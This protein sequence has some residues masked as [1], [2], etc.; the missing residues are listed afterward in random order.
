MNRVVSRMDHHAPSSYELKAIKTPRRLSAPRPVH[1]AYTRCTIHRI[2]T[3]ARLT[4]CQVQAKRRKELQREDLHA[5]SASQFLL[6]SS[7]PLFFSSDGGGKQTKQS[8]ALN[9]KLKVQRGFSP[10]N[11]DIWTINWIGNRLKQLEFKSTR[12]V[13]LMKIGSNR[14]NPSSLN[15]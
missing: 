13:R 5:G 9:W 11:K 1:V 3:S 10:S 7:L 4:L 15:G 14:R 2:I 12:V 6:S 8:S